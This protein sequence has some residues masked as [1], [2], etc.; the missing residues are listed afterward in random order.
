MDPQAGPQPIQFP[1]IENRPALPGYARAAA[2]EEPEDDNVQQA[3]VILDAKD[4]FARTLGEKFRN[5]ASARRMNVEDRWTMAW[6]NGIGKPKPEV[7]AALNKRNGSKVFVKVTSTKITAAKSLIMQVHAGPDGIQWNLQPTPIPELDGVNTGLL[8]EVSEMAAEMLP[9]EA[10]AQFMEAH[11]P[12]ELIEQVMSEAEARMSRMRRAIRDSMAEMKMDQ[13][14]VQGLDSYITYGTKV[15]QGPM[16][17]PRRRRRWLKDKEGKWTTALKRAVQADQDEKDAADNAG[18]LDIRPEYWMHS[19]W[20]I[21][22]DPASTSDRELEDLFVRHVYSPHDFRALRNEFGFD[23]EKIND[24][25]DRLPNGNWVSQPWENVVQQQ[26]SG[27]LSLNLPRYEVLEYWGWVTGAMLKAA[28]VDVPD[29]YLHADCVANIWFCGDRVIKAVVDNRQPEK[30]PFIFVPY[31]RRDG[32]IWGDGVP[33]QMEDTQAMWNGTQRAIMDNMRVTAGPQIVIDESR[34]SDRTDP[35]TLYPFKEWF[36]KDMEGLSRDPVYFFQPQN[37]V[38]HMAKIQEGLRL[39]MQMETSIPDFAT[40]IPGAQGHNRTEGGMILQQGMAMNFIRSQIANL[41]IHEIKP[42]IE[43]FYD[44]HMQFNPDESIK[45]DFEVV[46]GGVMAAMSNEILTGRLE[47]VMQAPWA[48]KI[49]KMDKV[50][51]EYARRIGLMD[52]DLA[53]TP[54]EIAS[55]EKQQALMEAEA[56]SIPK[57]ISPEMPPLNVLV[58]VFG[59]LQPGDPVRGPILRKIL[60]QMHT[61]TP[62]AAAAIDAM[63]QQAVAQHALNLSQADQAALAADITIQ[64]A[65]NG[66]QQPQPGTPGTPGAPAAPPVAPGP[67]APPANG[68]PMGSV[69]G[70]PGA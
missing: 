11:N 8:K 14:F 25:L 44:W 15:L 39:H 69:P 21:Y 9:P 30:I 62:D 35:S 20:S 65:M 70:V 46:A 54:D 61:L 58:Q 33:F 38:Q 36:V 48:D 1:A 22:P 13:F 28:G 52:L 56:Q 24:L 37:N 27:N 49:L 57:R 12:D 26:A 68:A 29:K 51:P 34:L 55:R 3:M 64:E 63:N 43:G 45:G 6:F 19:V 40:G 4:E 7:E 5:Y 41:D 16:S 47:R 59:G 31:Q 17:V 10:R 18:E 2:V 53:Y 50:L 42:M 23:E 32:S 66:A 67:G 60:E